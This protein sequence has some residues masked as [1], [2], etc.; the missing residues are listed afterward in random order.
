MSN[1]YAPQLDQQGLDSGVSEE[2][3]TA[4]AILN[5]VSGRSH[6]INPRLSRS[7][8]TKQEKRISKMLEAMRACRRASAD[9]VVAEVY[10]ILDASKTIEDFRERW[11]TAAGPNPRETYG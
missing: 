6:E 7:L 1:P 11:I 9:Y 8:S 2:I 4:I 10:E 3:G 5:A